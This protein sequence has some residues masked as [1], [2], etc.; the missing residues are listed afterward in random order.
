[1]AGAKPEEMISADVLGFRTGQRVDVRLRGTKGGY[2]GT[3]VKVVVPERG[4]RFALV[5]DD[6][7]RHR[8]ADFH[9][10]HLV[11]LQHDV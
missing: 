6:N 5:V 3:V 9:T 4:E 2:R 10:M 11:D 1:M 7:G 8:Y